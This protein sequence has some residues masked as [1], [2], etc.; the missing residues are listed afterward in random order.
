MVYFFVTAGLVALTFFWGAGLAWLVVPREWR[1]WS[2][3]FAPGL[4]W[5]LQ[6]G[7]VW[8]AAHT[9][10]NGT[11]AYARW[12]VLLPLGLLAVAVTRRRIERPRGA[13]GTIALILITGVML[14]W[15]MAEAGR[16]LTTSSLGSCDHADY[17]AGARTFHEFSRM[18]R[19]GFLGLP[20]VT[21]VR[22]TDYF[23]DYW[24]FLNHF[25]PSALIAHHAAF[26][27]IED[28]RLVSVTGVLF[29]LLN[30]PLAAMLMRVMVGAKGFWLFLWSALYAWSPI[31]FYAVAHGALGQMLAVQGIALVT[32]ASY[33]AVRAGRANRTGWSFLP[34]I[35]AA[36]W[37]LA[38]SY[39]FILLVCLAPAGAWML[40]QLLDEK[41]RRAVLRVIGVLGVAT[42]LC[43]ALAWGRFAG[44]AERFSLFEQY[45]F[46]WVVPLTSPEGWWGV[47]R[48]VSLESWP[49][50]VRWLA[51][52][53]LLGLFVVGWWQLRARQSRFA[54]TSLALVVPAVGGWAI[55]AWESRV[56]ANASYDAYKIL[57]VFLP[58]LLAG[59]GCWLTVVARSRS[60][61]Q[62]LALLFLL[63]LVAANLRVAEDFRRR[64]SQPPLRVSRQ[65]AEVGKLEGEPRIASL[66][67][68]IEDYWSRLWANSF[69]LRKPQYFAIHT[70]EGRKDTPLRGEWDLSDSILR[71]LPARAEDFV[72]VNER[73]FAVREAEV[74]PRLA[75]GP[76]WHTE[77]QSGAFRWRWSQGAGQIVVDNP[78]TQT[79]SASLELNVRAVRS[80]ELRVIWNGQVVARHALT[81]QPDRL[82]VAEV[83]I[84]P[85]ESRLVLES[86]VQAAGAGDG[87]SLGILLFLAVLQVR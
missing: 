82:V 67:M 23:F 19:T 12:S 78:S 48:T 33:G 2:W 56:R 3:A 87:R 30:L 53:A 10:L 21:R 34:L 14:L 72:S 38:G 24:L 62:R 46:G 86:E 36:L 29:H 35:F 68:Q 9:S 26:L 41:G 45:N 70:Y 59:L 65:L 1:R 47:V 74:R 39:N 80:L 52:S 76:G 6:S 13:V 79:L 71:G 22:S 27:G 58:G 7:V 63:T 31:N 64:M 50:G 55:L 32:L 84:P 43:V 49:A 8:V 20:E 61:M 25:S 85:G 44:L 18:D 83:I 4:G 37:L 60:I 40:T 77:E 51:S 5:A 73:F 11:D 57:S 42:I 17:A 81:E 28:Y 15:P 16:G 69:L 54:W 75:F 66:N